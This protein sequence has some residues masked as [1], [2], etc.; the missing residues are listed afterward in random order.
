MGKKS[1]A[2][3]VIAI[4]AV[5]AM[6]VA[7]NAADPYV[8]DSNITATDSTPAPG[9]PVTVNFGW[10]LHR[11]RE[12]TGTVTGNGTATLVSRQGRDRLDHQDG[13]KADRHREL[14]RHRAQEL[15]PAPTR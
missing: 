1:F 13:A 5:F 12:I 3:I 6:P 14:R 9:Q 7:A 10:G 4:A 15:R 11:W 2:A 8:P